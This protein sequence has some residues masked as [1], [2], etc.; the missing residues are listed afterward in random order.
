MAANGWGRQFGVGLFV[1]VALAVGALG[2]LAI[3]KESRLFSPKVEYS[4]AF[5]NIT[6]LTEGAPVRLSGVQVGTVK[7]IEFSEDLSRTE[8]LIVLSVDR[9]FRDR[10]RSD[11]RALLRP[12]SYLSIEK[13]IEITTGSPANVRIEP[14]GFIP[15]DITEFERLQ[16]AGQNIAENLQEITASMRGLMTAIT[17]GEGLVSELFYDEDFGRE[18]RDNIQEITDSV[19][20]ITTRIEAQEGLLGRLLFDEKFSARQL[21]T[22]DRATAQLNAILDSIE[23]GDGALGDLLSDD[24]QAMGA[25]AGF[26]EMVTN[27]R[28]VSESF[29]G[30]EGVLGGLLNDEE[31]GEQVLEKIR[32]IAANLESISE[33]LDRGEGTLGLM[34]ND[35]DVYLG[36]EDV[37]GG[38]RESRVLRALIKKYGKKGAQ[39]RVE[40]ALEEIERREREE[41]KGAGD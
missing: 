3:G 1:L 31:Y 34:I 22:I 28:E 16:A 19:R 38:I 39:E 10:I 5:S 14:G 11:S 24:G 17:E 41:R 27:L 29:Q 37:V 13:Y 33:K 15:P 35:P 8:I 20:R 18:T 2:I 12:L 25:I 32:N 23:S 21:E 4:T 7:S 6:G 36:L 26:S 30:T 40:S 9:S